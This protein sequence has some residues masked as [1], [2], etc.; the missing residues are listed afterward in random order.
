MNDNQ[1]SVTHIATQQ[2]KLDAIFGITGGKTV[3]EFL[4]GLKLDTNQISSTI[5]AI[6]ANVKAEVDKL[7]SLEVD[8]KSTDGNVSLSLAS[9]DDSL[10]SI[11][12]MIDLAKDVVRHV[13]DGI[14][15]TPLIDSEAVQA[16]S[17]LIESIHLNI[18]E[19]ISVYRD[20][21]NFANKVKFAIF[22]QEQKKEFALFK[23]N[24][25]LEKMK[26]KDGPSSIEPDGVSTRDWNQEQMTKF[27]SE[28]MD[29]IVDDS[30]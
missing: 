5:D 17:K 2:E 26:A 22:Q 13:A 15:A 27:L 14:L 1:I 3:D 24:L 29:D 10:K 16:Y 18:V 23:H 21:Q 4:D 25:D 8:V 19:F 12:D 11:E 9:M 30:K 6:D 28:H 7:D 20:K